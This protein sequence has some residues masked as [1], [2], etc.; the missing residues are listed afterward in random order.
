MLKHVMKGTPGW[1][2][3]HALAILFTL[4][5]GAVTRFAP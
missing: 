5:L 3:L 2:V 1:F 4:W